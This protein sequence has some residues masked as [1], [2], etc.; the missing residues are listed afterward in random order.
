[1]SAIEQSLYNSASAESIGL[2]GY[3][4]TG[5]YCLREAM[6]SD[7]AYVPISTWPLFFG[8]QQAF[9]G[10]LWLGIA[11]NELTVISKIDRNNSEDFHSCRFFLWGFIIFTLTLRG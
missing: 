9:E 4:P 3:I 7:K 1:M 5:I 2:S 11:A 6:A 8:I 10:L